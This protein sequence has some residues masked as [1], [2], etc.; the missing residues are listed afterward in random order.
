MEEIYVVS[1]GTIINNQIVITPVCVCREEERA[2][3]LCRMNDTEDEVYA[4]EMI[5]IVK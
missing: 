5:Y 1:K 2:K 4:Y 3:E